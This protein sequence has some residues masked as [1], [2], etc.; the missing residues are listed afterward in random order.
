MGTRPATKRGGRMSDPRQTAALIA[1]IHRMLDRQEW[2]IAEAER[3]RAERHWK[4][5]VARA[6]HGPYT[7]PQDASLP[8][9]VEDREAM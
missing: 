1:A 2:L 7:E 8:F 5:A 9:H 6:T 3:K 4:R